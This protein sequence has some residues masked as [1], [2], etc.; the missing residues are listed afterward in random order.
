MLPQMG[1][2]E[3]TIWE[4][5]SSDASWASEL[6]EFEASLAGKSGHIADIT[7]ACAVLDLIGSAYKQGVGGPSP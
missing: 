5:P 2:P 3:T 4:Y 1:P 6:V 7:D